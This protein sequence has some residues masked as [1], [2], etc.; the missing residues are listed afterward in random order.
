M[1]DPADKLSRYLNNESTVT[2]GVYN[3]HTM[4][5]LMHRLG[6]PHRDL[7]GV[8]IA[9]TNGKGSTAHMIECLFR[10]AGY[11]TGLYTSPHLL[12]INE[13]IRIDGHPIDDDRLSVLIDEILARADEEPPLQPTYF[14]ALTAVGFLHFHRQQA[15]CAVIEVGLG[16]RLDSTNVFKPRC[17]IITAISR[18]HAHILGNSLADIAMEKAGIIKQAIPVVS[19]TQEPEVLEVIERRCRDLEAPFFLAG[20]DFHISVLAEGPGGMTVSYRG[21]GTTPT[22]NDQFELPFVIPCQADNA[23]LALTVALLMREH[24]PALTRD[25]LHRGFAAATVPGR[26]ELLSPTIPLLYDPAHNP[27]AMAVLADHLRRRFAGRELVIVLS[28]MGDKEIPAIL[29]ELTGHRWRLIYYQLDDRRAYRPSPADAS[30]F[31]AVVDNELALYRLLCDAQEQRAAM[32]FT[33]SFRLYE[34]AR[35]MTRGLTDGVPHADQPGDA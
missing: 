21:P 17:S 25:A 5:R 10:H 35:S 7:P 8:H 3:L 29:N 13:R 26:L 1:A 32:C 2:P 4:T 23:A 28:L 15:E 33:G 6:D 16:G 31:S 34:T 19:A 9:G 18:D 22:S 27:A 24:Y 20:R 11:R 14:D 30:F 12:K